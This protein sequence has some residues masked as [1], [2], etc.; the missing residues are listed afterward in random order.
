MITFLLNFILLNEHIWHELVRKMVTKLFIY[1]F[2][3]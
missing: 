3:Q 1:R 2:L